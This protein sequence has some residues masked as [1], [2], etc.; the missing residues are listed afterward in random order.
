MKT[1]TKNITKSTK[2]VVVKGSK[3]QTEIMMCRP[4][5]GA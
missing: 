5:F 3:K 2:V 1:Q 4:V